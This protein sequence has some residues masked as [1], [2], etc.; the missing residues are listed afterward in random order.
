MLIS[1]IFAWREYAD[2]NQDDYLAKPVRGKTLEDMLVKWAVEG[3]RKS[4][5][6]EAFRTPHV[7]NSSICTAS[8]TSPIS[9]PRSSEDEPTPAVSKGCKAVDHGESEMIMQHIFS[10]EQAIVLRDEKLMAASNPNPRQL[11]ISLPPTPSLLR[12]K[13][14]TPALTAENMALLSRE[15]EVNPFDVLYFQTADEDESGSDSSIDRVSTPE[16][17]LVPLEPKRGLGRNSSSELT[18]RL[19]KKRLCR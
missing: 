14:P 16:G 7:D 17:D 8:S 3:K 5:L 11:S 6:S 4:R 9:H 15:L 19:G 10:E 13:L 18:V 12:V 1:Q 2:V